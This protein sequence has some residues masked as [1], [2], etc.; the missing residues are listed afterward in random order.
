[1]YDIT[2]SKFKNNRKGLIKIIQLAIDGKLNKL[3]IAHKDRLAR[4]GYELIDFIIKEY[5]NGEIIILNKKEDLEPEEEM[6]KDVL[7]IMNVFTTK[8]N[9]LRKYK[10]N[11]D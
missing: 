11:K 9:G 4:F 5:S 7:Q 8:M 3:I 6:V 2:I 10:K 1:M